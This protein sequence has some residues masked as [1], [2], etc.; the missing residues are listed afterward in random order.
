MKLEARNERIDM[1]V[2]D[3]ANQAPIEN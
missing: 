2:V 1:L 3:K